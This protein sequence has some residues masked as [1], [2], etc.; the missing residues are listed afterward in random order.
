MPIS[1]AADIKPIKW[2]FRKRICPPCRRGWTARDCPAKDRKKIRRQKRRT[3]SG[4]PLCRISE[5]GP[6]PVH[7]LSD[8]ISGWLGNLP[9]QAFAQSQTRRHSRFHGGKLYLGSVSIIHEDTQRLQKC[10]GA[11]APGAASQRQ[12]FCLENPSG[13]LQY[14]RKIRRDCKNALVRQHRELPRSDSIFV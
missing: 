14:T 2:F 5:A 8:T 3:V 13:F 6:Q 10:V 11:P 4:S 9:K 1:S 12:H 7:S